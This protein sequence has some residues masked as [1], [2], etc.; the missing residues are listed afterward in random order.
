VIYKRLDE[1]P[2]IPDAHTALNVEE[3][4]KLEPDVIFYWNN[5]E[6]VERLQAANIAAVPSVSSPGGPRFEDCKDMLMVY[7]QILGE[8]EVKIAEEYAEYFDK[9]LQM[10]T[11]ITSTIPEDERPKVYWARQE[12]LMTSGGNSDVPELIDL[13]GGNCVH[14]DLPGGGKTEINMEQLLEWDPDFIFVDHAGSSGN[15]PAEEVVSAMVDDERFSQ[16]TAVQQEQVKICPT[17]VFFWG[18]GQQRILLLMWMAKTLCPDKFIDLDMENELKYFYEK[19]F[20]YKL[21]DDQ[22]YK[23][24]MHLSPE[25]SS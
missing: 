5:P 20:D 16:L 7:A 21:S 19:F 1:V 2:G 23:I 4:L 18:A 6:E 8:D 12:L 22:A 11:A 24:L 14:R 10:V 3:I 17:G 13:A 15:A 25:G 9:K